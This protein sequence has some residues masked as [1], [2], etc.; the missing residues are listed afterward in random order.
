MNFLYDYYFQKP[1]MNAWDY[2][3]SPAFKNNTTLDYRIFNS[4][5]PEENKVGVW[6]VDAHRICDE[7]K[8]THNM[9][10]DIINKEGK[11]KDDK[12]YIYK[13]DMYGG[14]GNAFPIKKDWPDRKNVFDLIPTKTLNAIRKNKN[15]HIMLNYFQEGVIE[16]FHLKDIHDSLHQ[17][18]IP[19]NQCILQFGGYDIDDWYAEFCRNYAITQ[20]IKVIHHSWVWETKSNEFYNYKEDNNN[21]L[22]AKNVN[23]D[24]KVEIKKHNFNCLNRR[25]RTHRLYTLAVLEKYGMIDNNIVTYDFTIPENVPHLVE[26][27]TYDIAQNHIYNFRGLDKYLHYLM[28]DKPKKTYDYDDLQNLFGINHERASV[29]EDSMFSLVTETTVLPNEYYISEKVVKPIGHNHPFIVFGSV[30]TLKHLRKMGFKT[31]EP[32]IDESY[33]LEPKPERRFE[34]ILSQ[35]VK[36][37]SKS[38]EQKLKWMQDVKPIIE[39]NSKHLESFVNMKSYYDDYHWRMNILIEKK[40]ND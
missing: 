29:Y 14:I 23:D 36:L 12:K 22:S 5:N 2:K 7:T 11:T 19:T 13:I 8:V 21:L 34:M 30:G 27:T 28:N 26:L 4:S 1:F 16:Y 3:T 39:H 31:F 37:C 40:D 9:V 6:C 33:D 32:Y 25:L 38:E 17:L 20:K 15:I 18:K 24:Y 35:V 10:F